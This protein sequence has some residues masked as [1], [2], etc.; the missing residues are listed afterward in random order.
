MKLLVVV[1]CFLFLAVFGLTGAQPSL[2]K[3]VGAA[4]SVNEHQRAA[5]PTAYKMTL[6]GFAN[7][8]Y[9]VIVS[10]SGVRVEIVGSDCI[11]V[12]TAPSWSVT[13]WRTKDKTIFT[14]SHEV[15]CKSCQLRKYNWTADL[16]PSGV[17]RRTKF[18]NYPAT[19]SSFSTSEEVDLALRSSTEAVTAGITSKASVICLSFKNAEKSGAIIARLL[20]MQPLSGFPVLV[21]RVLSDGGKGR[22]LVPL[23]LDSARVDNHTFSI[24]SGYK[25][26][27]FSE[28]FFQS[29]EKS[30]QINDLF[31]TFSK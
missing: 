14:A 21:S 25:P 1:C 29:K 5:S 27:C 30:E 9:R 10:D 31:E 18:R 20:G 26:V 13:A 7:D 12:S 8:F 6:R 15:W 11:I 24:P 17:C 2:S 16:K 23:S 4:V 19:E 22:C 3:P 28:S